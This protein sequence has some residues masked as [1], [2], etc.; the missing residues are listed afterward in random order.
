M[1]EQEILNYL[2]SINQRLKD[3]NGIG[4][5]V[6]S[7]KKD[8]AELDHKVGEIFEKT[9]SNGKDIDFINSSIVNLK[10]DYEKQNNLIWE[11]IHKQK[12]EI[13]KEASMKFKNWV[14]ASVLAGVG[15]I[16][17]L[18]ISKLMG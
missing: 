12:D 8:L 16:A 3:L 14:F 4:P 7:I 11:K 15:A 17:F 13:I 5:D 6:K 1:S 9:I 10:T 2:A 18:I